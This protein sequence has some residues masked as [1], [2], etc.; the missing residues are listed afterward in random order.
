MSFAGYFRARRKNQGRNTSDFIVRP[1]PL[2]F[3]SSAARAVVIASGRSWIS[4]NSPCPCRSR[5]R[6]KKCCMKKKED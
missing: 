5:K 2:D 4:R 3:L 1:I 6:F